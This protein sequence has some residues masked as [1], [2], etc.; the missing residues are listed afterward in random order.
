MKKIGIITLND[1]YNYGNRL[2]NYAAQEFIKKIE[3]NAKV[4]TIRNYPIT[5][6]KCNI[7]ENI[8]RIIKRNYIEIKRYIKSDKKRLRKFKKFNKKIVYSKKA[9]SWMNR[10]Y[11]G[12]FDFGVVESDQVW[13][14][15]Y[16][17]SDLELLNFSEKNKN[18]A[19]SASLEVEE[20]PTEKIEYAKRG[21]NNF[22]CISVRENKGREII[23]K[24]TNREDIK[25][26]LDPTMLIETNIWKKMAIKPENFKKNQKFI[27][28]YFLGEIPND[29]SKEIERI[30]Y[31]I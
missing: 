23:K 28:N 2:Q 25:V 15:N 22:K 30:F 14:P 16:R 21:F 24:I 19:F 26:I 13:N 9:F 7:L 11:F 10:K 20:I 4:L 18:I 6:K 5:N 3:P 27:L 29:W 17:M 1:N 31:F 12:K 8:F